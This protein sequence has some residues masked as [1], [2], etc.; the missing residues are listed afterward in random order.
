MNT[1]TIW[2]WCP[3]KREMHAMIKVSLQSRELLWRSTEPLYGE[4]CHFWA[5][6]T[7][8]TL[9]FVRI[10]KII[11]LI[12]MTKN[13]TDF[14]FP[15]KN[16]EN[17]PKNDIFLAIFFSSKNP[18]DWISHPNFSYR[19][20]C[21]P[22]V[23]KNSCVFV[24]VLRA[25]HISVQISRK[26]EIMAFISHSFSVNIVVVDMFSYPFFLFSFLYLLWHIKSTRRK[27]LAT[28]TRQK[29]KQSEIFH[30]IFLGALSFVIVATKLISSFLSISVSINIIFVFSFLKDV[31]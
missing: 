29:K 15:W 11:N 4:K 8:F 16:T 12:K 20:T 13:V 18:L 24:L 26:S 6:F 5:N 23:I 28:N 7:K 3:C 9:I 10:V 22:E 27:M 25:R 31:A 2:W 19:E 1:I 14:R 30:V 21:K 17:R